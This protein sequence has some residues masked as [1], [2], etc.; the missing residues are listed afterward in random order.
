MATVFYAFLGFVL[1]PREKYEVLFVAALFEVEMNVAISSVMLGDGYEFMI[2]TLALIPG[3][4]YLAHTWPAESK[5]RYGISMLPIVSTFL[6]AVMY[7]V[8]DI[9]CTIIP[10]VYTGAAILKIRPI[11]HYFNIMIAV[12]LLFAFS[13]LFALEVRYIQ[14]LLNDENS[15]LGEIAAKDPLTKALNRRSFYHVLND[16]IVQ[17]EQVEF[18][19]I[20]LDID[21]FKKVN[22]T[23]GHIVGD[24]V[25]IQTATAIKENMRE[26]DS[27]AKQ[28]FEDGENVFSV[29]ATLGIAE[30]QMGIQIRTLIDMADQKLYFGKKHGKNQVVK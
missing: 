17:N 3:A 6:V 15:R 20:I 5:N 2:Y 9:M 30:Y 24:Q 7:I 28:V 29:T 1:A 19:L 10:P 14:K 25:L 4:F 27:I 8:V 23:Y 11:F 12:V 22:D 21:D 13:V 18:G 26:G 16:A